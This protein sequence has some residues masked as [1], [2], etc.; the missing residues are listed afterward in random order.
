[1]Q[2]DGVR[3]MKKRTDGRMLPARDAGQ[4]FLRLAMMA[5]AGMPL[6]TAFRAAGTGLDPDGRAAMSGISDRIAAGAYPDDAMLESGLFGRQAAGLVAAGAES[7]RLEDALLALHSYYARVDGILRRAKAALMQPAAMLGMSV[8]VFLLVCVKI[9]P[10]FDSV[11]ASMGTS[12]DGLPGAL[13]AFGTWLRHNSIAIGCALAG[14]AVLIAIIWIIPS[15]RAFIIKTAERSFGDRGP[16][17]KLSDARF[18]QAVSMGLDAGLAPDEACRMA[19]SGY[20]PGSSAR[21]RYDACSEGLSDGA[22]LHEMLLAHGIV[23]AA[24]SMLVES[25]SLAGREPDAVR[26]AAAMTLSDAEQALDKLSGLVEPAVTAAGS[27][28]V[29]ATVLSAMLPLLG[30]MASLG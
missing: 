6:A 18:V 17:R 14:T 4:A 26:E 27:L 1:M 13:L 11:Y 21:A 29:G 2:K 25:G 5:G 28:L 20:E 10:V 8:L 22:R 12:L 16:F 15:S 30:V 7:G 3:P 24:C 9:L 19:A 23:D